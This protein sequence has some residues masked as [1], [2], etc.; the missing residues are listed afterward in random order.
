MRLSA[1]GCGGSTGPS[2][3]SRIGPTILITAVID[4][5]PTAPGN[6]AVAPA[7][8]KP[9]AEKWVVGQ[10]GDLVAELPPALECVDDVC[11]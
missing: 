3:T 7:L 10:P 11:V 8:G 6:E 9:R 4:A 5:C 2:A 1:C